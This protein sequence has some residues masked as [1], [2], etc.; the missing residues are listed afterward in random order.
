MNA[1]EGAAAEAAPRRGQPRDAAAAATLAKYD[2]R[3]RIPIILSAVLPLIIVPAQGNWVAVLVGVVSWLVFAVDLVVHQRLI[4]N[5]LRTHLGRFDLAIVVLTAPW[6]LI[7]GAHG[8]SFVVV[9]RLARLSRLLIATKGVRRL[10]ARLG[11]VSIVALAVLFVGAAM[12][13]YAEHPVN[14]EFATF[15]DAVWWATV[16]LTTVGYGD[17]VPVTRAGRVDAAAIMFMGVALLGLLAGSLASFF[18]LQ[19]QNG[20]TRQQDGDT[21]QQASDQAVLAELARLREQVAELSGL[22]DQLTAL[23]RHL[24]APDQPAPDQPAPG[25]GDE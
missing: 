3:A 21:R 20:D 13:Y 15:G 11:R 19:N 1:T 23:T 12:A 2:R 8:G 18:G 4:V 5:Y 7:G 16:T 9:L 24:A 22:R 14:P 10:F 25:P 17:I 6:F